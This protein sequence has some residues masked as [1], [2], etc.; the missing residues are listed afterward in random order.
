MALGSPRDK[1][2]PGS[3]SRGRFRNHG[4]SECQGFAGTTSSGAWRTAV[5]YGW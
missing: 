4:T 3:E 1:K 2:A 5:S